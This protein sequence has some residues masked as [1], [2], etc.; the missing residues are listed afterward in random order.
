MENLPLTIFEAMLLLNTGDELPTGYRVVRPSM[1]PRRAVSI[2]EFE[3]D[4]R[5]LSSSRQKD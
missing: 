5:T 2:E 4:M 1:P 3:A